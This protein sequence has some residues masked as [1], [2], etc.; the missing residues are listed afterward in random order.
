MS[1]SKGPA[2]LVVCGTILDGPSDPE[3]GRLAEA[4]AIKAE[5]TPVAFGLVGSERIKLLEGELP[6][7]TSFTAVEQFSSMAAL[8]AFWYSDDY[9]AAIPH[10]A[11]SVKMNFVVAVDGITGAEMA[12]QA[13]AIQKP[14]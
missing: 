3:Y 14:K 5:L 10:R 6:A 4:E 9:Q 2:F 11:G 7:G 13:E 8:E 12:A 1:D